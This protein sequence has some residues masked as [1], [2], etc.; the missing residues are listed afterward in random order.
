[1][2]EIALVLDLLSDGKW[3]GMEEL[4]QVL[5]LNEDKFEVIAAFLNK[6]DF[7]KVDEKN[8]RIKINGDFRSLPAQA[9][10]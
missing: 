1:V 3:H 8:R 7:V 9:I 4:M 6:Y 2:S 10:I 5:G